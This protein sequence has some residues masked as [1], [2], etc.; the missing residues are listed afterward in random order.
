MNTYPASLPLLA[1]VLVLGCGIVG[2]Q[3]KAGTEKD[4]AS[5]DTVLV[6]GSFQGKEGIKTS[7][8]YRIGRSGPDLKLVLGE[9]FQTE[10]GPD[11]HV[12]L[13]PKSPGDATGENVTS[14]AATKVA[15]LRSL[16]GQ[17]AYDLQD[18][19]DLKPFDSVAI[20][21][22]QFSHLYGV[23]KLD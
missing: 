18:D 10:S 14:G 7:G 13:S 2:S 22:I 4:G 9:D 3:D 6:R 17:Q 15:P 11:L 5:L 8:S 23:A 16:K 12:V 21:C 19:L 20:Q 1:L